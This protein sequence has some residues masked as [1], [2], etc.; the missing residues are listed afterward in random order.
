MQYS[1]IAI[2]HAVKSILQGQNAR[3]GSKLQR[4]NARQEITVLFMLS[5][6]PSEMVVVAAEGGKLYGRA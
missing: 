5:S 4:Q 6:G 1:M 2:L 3:L